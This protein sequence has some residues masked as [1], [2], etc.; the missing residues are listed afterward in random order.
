MFLIFGTLV[1]VLIGLGMRLVFGWR[2]AVVATIFAAKEYGEL[3]YVVPGSVTT[4]GKNI[5]M[6]KELL[7]NPCIVPQWL[8]PALAALALGYYLDKRNASN[9]STSQEIC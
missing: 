2:F 1:H 4:V 6:V 7:S 3:K 9:V 8:L 5:F